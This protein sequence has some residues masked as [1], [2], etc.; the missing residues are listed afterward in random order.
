MKLK[1]NKFIIF[2]VFNIILLIT[3]LVLSIPVS[4]F[5]SR[6]NLKDNE[7]AIGQSI[8]QPNAKSP[9]IIDRYI[10]IKFIAEVDKLLEWEFISLEDSARIRIGEMNVVSYEGKN[11]SNREITSTAN[12]MSSPDSINP[13]IIK[14]ECFCFQKQTLLPGESKTFTMIFYI[15]PSLDSVDKFKDLKELVFTYE[16]SEYKS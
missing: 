9:E 16:F 14:T 8:I 11:I 12:F 15:D 6:V 4:N 5:L 1:K 3:L 2:Y 13:Y 7:N 10:N